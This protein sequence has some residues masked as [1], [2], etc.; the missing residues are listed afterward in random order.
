[1]YQSS[2]NDKEWNDKEWNLIKRHF[3]PTDKRGNSYKH[4]KKQL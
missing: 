4:E 3:N 2:L 1:M